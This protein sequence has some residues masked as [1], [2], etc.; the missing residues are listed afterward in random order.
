MGG[1][2]SIAVRLAGLLALTAVLFACTEADINPTSAVAAKWIGG[3]HI[4]PSSATRSERTEFLTFVGLDPE[5]WGNRIARDMIE[6]DAKISAI[7]YPHSCSGPRGTAGLGGDVGQFVAQVR[8][9]I[10]PTCVDRLGPR[11]IELLNLFH[12]RTVDAV[13]K[14][15][16]IGFLFYS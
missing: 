13:E 7:V 16:V 4:L 11:Q 1:L 14:R 2:K 15:R 8:K 5:G 6:P 3:R 10:S 12:E 9:E